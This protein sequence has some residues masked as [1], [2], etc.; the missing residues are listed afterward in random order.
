MRPRTWYDL[1]ECIWTHLTWKFMFTLTFA[2]TGGVDAALHELFWNVCRSAERIAR[3]KME[4]VLNIFYAFFGK[5]IGWVRSGH[6][7]MEPWSHKCKPSD[8][9]F[10]KIGASTIL[11]VAI[12]WDMETCVIQVRWW[13][14]LTFDFA[15]WSFEGHPRPLTLTNSILTYIL[16]ILTDNC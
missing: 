16:C 9:F 13:P 6:G 14:Y 2:G 12:D 10:A 3:K 7:A 8:R 5:T 11:L 4:S 1:V 15:S